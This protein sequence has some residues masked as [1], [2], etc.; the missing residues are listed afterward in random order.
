[1]EHIEPLAPD[2]TEAQRVAKPRRSS[3]R[4]KRLQRFPETHRKGVASLTRSSPRLEDLADSFPALLFAL[5][6]NYATPDA[7]TTA[8]QMVEDGASLRDVSKALGLPYWL[9]RLPAGA[10]SSPLPPLPMGADFAKRIAP[11]VPERTLEAG[12][13]LQRIAFANDACDSDFALWLA[14]Q[15]RFPFRR[16]APGPLALLASWAWHSRHGRKTY[17]GSFLRTRWD[18]RLSLKRAYDEARSWQRRLD[19]SIILAGGLTDTWFEPA[20]I[21]GYDFVPLT[22]IDDFLNESEVMGNCLDQYAMPMSTGS[23][24]VFSIRKG[25]THVANVELAPHDDDPNMPT[26]EQLRGPKNTRV[27]FEIWRV[28]YAWLGGQTFRPLVRVCNEE[29]RELQ[30]QTIWGDYL[31]AMKGRPS[32]SRARIFAR[33]GTGGQRLAAHG[34]DA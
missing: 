34:S 14:R 24:R 12:Q 5:A 9:R 19:L 16:Q 28:V 3:V 27:K 10:F 4:E 21:D 32:Y 17:A 7:R 11:H 15:G 6:S 25:E 33:D 2:D 30:W 23:V 31:G 18:A 13:W 29:A 1:M 20:S 8:C 22:T 26:I